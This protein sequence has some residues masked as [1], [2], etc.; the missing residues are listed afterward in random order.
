[1]P[2]AIPQVVRSPVD[3]IRSSD[4][5]LMMK[6]EAEYQ[7]AYEADT[8]NRERSYRNWRAYIALDGG[9]WPEIDLANIRT[10]DRNAVQF[11]IIGPKVDTLA[12][13]LAAESYDL[14]WKP[15]KGVRN[16]LT[17]S[18][19]NA[20]FSDKELCN[21]DSEI[22]LIA[23]DGLVQKGV[24]KMQENGDHDP[25][26]NIAFK[27]AM[28]GHVIFDPHWITE[29][30]KDCMKAWEMF[31][32]PAMQIADHYGIN[33]VLID[34]AVRQQ[35]KYGFDYEE[36]DPDF[37]QQ[38]QLGIRGSLYRVIEYH[39]MEHIKIKRLVGNILGTNEFLPFP[40]T[41]DHNALERYMVSNDID[42]FTIKETPYTDKIH[43]YAAI[44]P[45]LT[46]KILEHGVSR[47]QPKRL[48]Y[49]QFSA[50]RGLG[51]DKGIVDDIMDIQDTINRRESKLTDM[52][53]TAQGGGKLVNRDLFRSPEARARFQKFAND[54]KYIEFVDG[55]ELSKEKSIQY[56]NSNQY[57]SQIINQ[58]ERM[59]EIVDKISK[60]PAAMEAMSESTN[61]SG[62]LFNR[63]LQV[64]RLS[65]A[66]IMGRMKRLRVNL[67][68]AYYW[69][70][71]LTY[72]GP[73]REFSTAD[74]K[75]KTV[76]NE[77]IFDPETEK[78][79]I[80]NRPNMI[81]RV[82]VIATEARNSPNQMLADQALY[83]ELFSNSAQ[84]NPDYANIFYEQLLMSMPLGEDVKA[85]VAEINLLKRISTR[86]KILA[87]LAN[88]DATE[89]QSLLMSAQA[90]TQLGQILA[91]AGVAPQPNVEDSLIEDE[92]S[93][94]QIPQ[95]FGADESEE[96]EQTASPQPE[97]VA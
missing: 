72:N 9:Q 81:P 47:I 74:G 96:F 52:I 58:L 17:E 42:P 50:N 13:S 51:K 62:V 48:P 7:R 73:E 30:D 34:E 66:T 21:Y 5:E 55:E 46:H 3:G 76:L 97:G 90:A 32:I 18:V 67:A 86:K 12:A 75:H 80:K 38:L 14:D 10:E 33:S 70:F 65:S 2:N 64:A 54:P 85:Q 63:K 60:V 29:N 1:M 95:D 56:I 37:S 8:K 61:E 28:P 6:I 40:I 4:H 19:K 36:Y 11:N 93:P 43:K 69:Q 77:R 41:K 26:L 68:E 15:I 82:V 87:E 94:E 31:H 27:R 16:S 79:Y 57:P 84:T 92:E 89:K 71:Q 35:R 25:L 39:W 88:F 53:E 45:E 83:S 20:W 91:Q 78:R 49:F 59:Y 22:E 23:R 44:C 24:L